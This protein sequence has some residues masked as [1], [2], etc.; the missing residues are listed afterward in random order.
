MATVNNKI[1]KR[2][3]KVCDKEFDLTEYVIHIYEEQLNFLVKIYDGVMEV[4]E[5]LELASD[6][7]M[8]EEE[9]LDLIVED[10]AS[11]VDDKIYDKPLP[12]ILTGFENCTNTHEEPI[13][14][15]TAAS[16]STAVI[17][18]HTENNISADPA[19]AVVSSPA[20][21]KKMLPNELFNSIIDSLS[22]PKSLDLSL[23]VINMKTSEV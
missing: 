15:K 10:E 6:V 11:D 20:S 7:M 16:V 17:P 8:A 4:K 21:S 13:L 3:C 5:Y 14:S 1:P 9:N 23:N 22:Q 19:A 12:S 2:K 18:I